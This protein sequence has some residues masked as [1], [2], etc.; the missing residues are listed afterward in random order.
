MV[1]D[2]DFGFQRVPLIE[3]APLVAAVFD[4]VAD[5]YDHMNDILSLGLHRQWKKTAI[6]LC[7]M[8]KGQ[9]VLDIGGGSGD[10]SLLAAARV[11]KEGHI[12]LSDINAN[13]L[14]VGRD[15]MIDAG[16]LH[17]IEVVQADGEALPFPSG[18]FDHVT[19]GFCLR[20]MS[21]PKAALAAA[22]RVLKPGGRLMILE[23]SKPILP[24]LKPV[25]DFYNFKV[26]PAL[27]ALMA[28]DRASYQYLAESIERHPNQ[29]TLQ[30][31]LEAA[32]FLHCSYRNLSGGIVA[33]HRGVK[34]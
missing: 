5:K 18:M 1:D 4:R 11:G 3:K 29:E 32:G 9:S 14:A 33:V 25:Y 21:G 24:G 26:V 27:G 2:T 31:W 12:V 17:A 7:H 20:N 16:Y 28:Q 22:H 19:I 15:R 13:M 34:L 23:F 6:A 8:R 10:L 30:S